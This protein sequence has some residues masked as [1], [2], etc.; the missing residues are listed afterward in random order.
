MRLI[1]PCCASKQFMYIRDAIGN[2]GKTQ[3]HA[4]GD[5]SLT[6]LL[7]AIL[8]RYSETTMMI[9]APAI[10]D[11]AAEII[12]RW[13][14]KQWARMD[15]KGKLDVISKLTIIADLSKDKSP[16]ASEWLKDNPFGDRLVLVDRQQPDT[17][18]LMQD[19]VLTGPINF[20]YDKP[21]VC[22]VTAVPDEIAALW[23]YYSKL[24]RKPKRTAKKAEEP[25]AEAEQPKDEQPEAE[26]EQSDSSN[27]QIDSSN[28]V[29]D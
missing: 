23:K 6:E 29:E 4:Y 20:Q 13:L 12:E 24:T 15:G 26:T 18:I 1:E 27:E 9:V 22:D 17:A 11:Q 8:T 28:E 16:V 19:I 25:K 14:N 21:F 10:P 5:L 2:H 3:F 7:P